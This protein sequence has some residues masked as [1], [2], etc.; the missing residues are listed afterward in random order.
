[1]VDDRILELVDRDDAKLI[2]ESQ[3]EVLNKQT[4]LLESIKEQT[5]SRNNNWTTVLK[6]DLNSTHRAY[7]I[8]KQRP[9][10]PRVNS[11]TIPAQLVDYVYEIHPGSPVSIEAG[12]IMDIVAHDPEVL[13]ITNSETVDDVMDIILSGVKP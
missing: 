3:L 2:A 4:E 6:L 13:W 7:E 8:W 9:D 11:I 1:M 5:V 10:E 12:L